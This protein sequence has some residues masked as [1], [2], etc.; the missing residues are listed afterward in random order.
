MYI[1][2]YEPIPVE[3]LLEQGACC[4]LGCHNCPYEPRYTKGSTK[5]YTPPESALETAE[6]EGMPTKKDA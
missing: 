4:G 3:V 6:W 5:L 2:P 1:L